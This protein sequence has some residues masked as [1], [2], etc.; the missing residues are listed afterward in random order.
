MVSEHCWNGVE[1]LQLGVPLSHFICFYSDGGGGVGGGG[2]LRRRE[3]GKA[4]ALNTLLAGR[5][6]H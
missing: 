1:T 2:K 5:G 6:A 3:Y 4:L